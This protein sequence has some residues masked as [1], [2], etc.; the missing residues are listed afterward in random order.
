MQQQFAAVLDHPIDHV[1]RTRRGRPRG[2]NEITL[3]G[4]LPEGSL[5]RVEV[6]A[7][8]RVDSRLATGG[9]DTRGDGGGVDIVDLP[10][11]AVEGIAGRDEFVARRDDPNAGS[12]ADRHAVDTEC[13]QQ[14]DLSR[15]QPGTGA[16]RPRAGGDVRAGDH[17]VLARC[18][19]R[20]AFDFRVV[21]VVALDLGRSLDDHN[22]VGPRRHDRAGRNLGAG[23]GLDGHVGFFACVDGASEIED[24]GLGLVGADRVARADGIA[25]HRRAVEP[26]HVDPGVD[27]VGKHAAAGVPE[28]DVVGAAAEIEVGDGLADGF[29][30]SERSELLF[31]HGCASQFS[32]VT[33]S[34]AL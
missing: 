2:E 32:T 33:V 3:V 10:A 1:D 13:R 28:V 18:D 17:H 7:D 25:V 26:R 8:V 20:P 34:P 29:G 6:V 22:R 24:R 15:C 11:V 16:E 23:A 14:A 19:R 31:R 30:I 12:R 9:L 4:S 21:G 5:H 27:P